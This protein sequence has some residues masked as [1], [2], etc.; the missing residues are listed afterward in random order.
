[1]ARNLPLCVYGHG[2][3]AHYLDG[4]CEIE[5]VEDCSVEDD[6]EDDEEYGRCAVVNCIHYAAGWCYAPGDVCVREEDR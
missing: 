3:C 1:M 4:L 6:W 2:D 5:D